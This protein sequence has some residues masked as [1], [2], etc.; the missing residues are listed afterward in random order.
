MGRVYK[1]KI[2][3]GFLCARHCAKHFTVYYHEDSESGIA[4]P[5]LWVREWSHSV[6]FPKFIQL[7]SGRADI[8]TQV[9]LTPKSQDT[10]IPLNPITPIYEYYLLSYIIPPQSHEVTV[11][12]HVI[13]LY[14]CFLEGLQLF[15]LT[16]AS[17]IS[18]LTPR[19][20][21]SIK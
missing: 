2:C 12:A 4:I 1:R 21:V 18:C 7:V 3:W 15:F 8:L 13:F 19:Y 9:Y 6:L 11:K 10:H 20:C 5:I 16:F 14:R 17:G